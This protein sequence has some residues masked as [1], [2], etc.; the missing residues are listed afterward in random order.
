MLKRNRMNALLSLCV[1][2]VVGGANAAYFS[3]KWLADEPD[4]V[5]CTGGGWC[6][7]SD[8]INMVAT[9]VAGS[10]ALIALGILMVMVFRWRQIDARERAVPGDDF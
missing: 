7:S 10:I 4:Y 3:Y 2:T 6:P 5:R 1:L 8:T 9:L